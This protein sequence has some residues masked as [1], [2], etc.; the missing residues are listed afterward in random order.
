[1]DNWLGLLLVVALVICFIWEFD[2]VFGLLG[3]VERMVGGG[4]PGTLLQLVAKGPQDLYLT[5]YPDDL[6]PVGYYPIRGAKYHYHRFHPYR[7]GGYYPVM[8]F[9]RYGW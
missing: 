4:S 7:F 8:E 3:L 6:R 5:G 2:N 1:M 9:P